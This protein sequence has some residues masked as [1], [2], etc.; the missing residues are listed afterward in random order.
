MCGQKI[1]RRS[2]KRSYC[3]HVSVHTESRHRKLILALSARYCRPKK[4]AEKILFE[5]E[6]TI[7]QRA[8]SK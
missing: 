6:N 7:Q 3:L 5:S 4:P 2:V 8:Q 1:R